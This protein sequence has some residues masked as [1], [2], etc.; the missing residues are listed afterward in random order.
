[1]EIISGSKLEQ[2]KDIKKEIETSYKIPKDSFEL[3]FDNNALSEEKTLS[4]YNIYYASTIYLII[5]QKYEKL[6]LSNI[7]ENNNF[8]WLRYKGKSW[9]AGLPDLTI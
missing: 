7:L 5:E 8:F 4:D 9:T 6:L 3:V 2:I 1:M